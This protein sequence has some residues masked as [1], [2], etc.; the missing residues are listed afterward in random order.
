VTHHNINRIEELPVSSQVKDGTNVISKTQ[1]NIHALLNEDV[2]EALLRASRSTLTGVEQ[3]LKEYGLCI[4]EFGVLEA[5]TALGPQTIQV[6]AARVL[7]TSGSMTYTVN[8]LLKKGLI[9]RKCCSDDARRYYL[10]LTTEG[11]ELIQNAIKAHN[12]SVAHT[13]APLSNNDKC[14]LV[15]LLT[16]LFK[17]PEDKI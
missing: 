13:F 7:I 16:P 1:N 5:I 14:T 2:L 8:Q 12:E 6:L 17:T 10:H 11:K 4:T 15:A 9:M 3:V